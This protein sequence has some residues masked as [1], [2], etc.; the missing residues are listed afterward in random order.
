MTF[1]SEAELKG[2]QPDQPH[3][4]MDLKHDEPSALE[5]LAYSKMITWAQ[6]GKKIPLI[7]DLQ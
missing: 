6:K 2:H 1:Y 4:T 7:C 3:V 5:C